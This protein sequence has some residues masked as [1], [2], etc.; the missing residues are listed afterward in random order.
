MATINEIQTQGYN[1]FI[2]CVLNNKK[3]LVFNASDSECDVLNMLLDETDQSYLDCMDVI[4]NY[5]AW[6]IVG[7]E[8]AHTEIEPI[9]FSD[10]STAL[11][12]LVKEANAIN[13]EILSQGWHEAASEIAD[14]IAHVCETAL[15]LGFDGEMR[16]T[17]SSVFGWV[18]HNRETLEGCAIY[19]DEKSGY[20]PRKV[21]GELYAV[22]HEIASGLYISACWNPELNEG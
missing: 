2:E 18:P 11:E 3:S 8:C 9:D 6:Q 5:E 7:G 16:I 15:E 22:E 19:D 20:F 12:C 17:N 1:A 14:R 10:C 21:E 4:Y 13:K